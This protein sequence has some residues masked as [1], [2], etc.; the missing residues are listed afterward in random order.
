MSAIAF[1]S[2]GDKY[3]RIV[4][5]WENIPSRYQVQHIQNTVGTGQP[6]RPRT[7]VSLIPLSDTARFWKPSNTFR[8]RRPTH[9]SHEHRS[10]Q[11]TRHGDKWDENYPWS[12]RVWCNPYGTDECTEAVYRRSHPCRMLPNKYH[13]L[14]GSGLGIFLDADLSYRPW[15]RRVSFAAH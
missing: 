4:P 10:D 6:Y 7:C 14:L 12:A 8:S 9:S 15:Q 5:T 1:Y 13:I 2:A 3:D 11:N